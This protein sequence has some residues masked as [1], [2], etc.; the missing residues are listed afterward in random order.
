MDALEFA[1]FLVAFWPIVAPLLFL[2]WGLCC[3]YL[4]ALGVQELATWLEGRFSAA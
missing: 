3:V 2:F 4:A 1:R